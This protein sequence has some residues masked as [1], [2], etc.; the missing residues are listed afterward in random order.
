MIRLD[1]KLRPPVLE[2][3]LLAIRLNAQSLSK[4]EGR[5]LIHNEHLLCVRVLNDFSQAISF[6]PS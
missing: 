2:S 6:N 5:K 4:L 3:V 1:F